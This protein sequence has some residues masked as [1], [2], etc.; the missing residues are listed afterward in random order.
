LLAHGAGGKVSK[1]IR[2]KSYE[3]MDAGRRRSW[4]RRRELLGFL[5]FIL[6][7]F[8]FMILISFDAGDPSIGGYFSSSTMTVHNYGGSVGAYLADFLVSLLGGTAVLLP[9]FSLYAGIRL[10]RRPREGVILCV[11]SGLGLILSIDTFF[12]LRFIGDPIFRGGF[13]PG[14]IV[15]SVLGQ[16]ALPFFGHPGSYLLVFAVGFLS[17][18]GITGLSFRTL[19]LGFLWVASVLRKLFRVMKERRKKKKVRE[20]FPQTAPPS[21]PAEDLLEEERPL[22]AVKETKISVVEPAVEWEPAKPAVPAEERQTQFGFVKGIMD[23]HLPP[24]SLLDLPPAADR[25]RSRDDLQANGALLERKLLDFGVEG[26]VVQVLP[27]PVVTMYEFEPASGVKVA[28]IVNLADDLALGMRATSVRIVAPIPGKAVVGIEIPNAQRE[29]VLLRE[30][31]S[32]PEFQKSPSKLTFGLGKDILGRPVVTD[33]AQIPHLLIAGATGS[34][35]SVGINSMI[36]SILFNSTPDEVKFIMIDPKMLELSLYDGIPHLISPVVTHPKKAAA[37]LKWAV[38]EMERRYQ[39]MAEWGARNLASF[40][41]LIR[42]SKEGKGERRREVPAGDDSPQPSELPLLLIVIDELA[43]LMMVSSRE[44]EDCLTRLAQMARASGIHLLLA[45]QRPSVDVLTGI[46]KANFPARISFQVSS[47]TDS[48]TILDSSGGE[49]LLGKGDMLF[50]PPG[51]SK[52]QRIHGAFVSDVEIRRLVSFLKKSGRPTYD[53]SV[54]RP[55]VFEDAPPEDGERDDKYDEAVALVAQTGQA[56][57]SMVQR[58]LRIGFNRAARLIEIMEQEGLVGPA[59][60]GKPREVYVK[61][62]TSG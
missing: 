51:T 21:V 50:L 25:K 26:K 33:L 40:N 55:Q 56:S 18:M 11:A 13:E 60:S 17:F 49:R 52:M 37:A 20:P 43:D 16:P 3:N 27:G 12:Y 41:E 42:D 22:P 8:L 19:G 48:R 30:I 38:M 34:G 44:V 61:P 54:T 62:K 15:G 59:E 6:S 57:I 10:W 39:V 24:L 53:D 7:I 2:V 5:C 28:R 1:E 31:L 46:I 58:R 32:S 47:K 36:C 23:F 45:T 29:P 4:R 35:K 14:G 9:V